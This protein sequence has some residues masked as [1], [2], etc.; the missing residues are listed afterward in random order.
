[1]Q[2]LAVTKLQQQVSQCQVTGHPERA[3]LC[4]QG[5]M[6]PTQVHRSL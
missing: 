6:T 2:I 4:A 1:M 3:L 5:D